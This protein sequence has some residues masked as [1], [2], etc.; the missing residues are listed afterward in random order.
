MDNKDIIKE[1]LEILPEDLKTLILG[2]TWR[3]DIRSIGEEFG[4][5]EEKEILLENEVFMV[6]MG[7]ELKSDFYSNIKETLAIGEDTAKWVSEDV[8]KYVFNQVL[9]ILKQIEYQFNKSV[10]SKTDLPAVNNNIGQSFEK[11]ILN[12]AKAMQPARPADEPVGIM[13]SE[14][15]IMNRKGQ[16]PDNLPAGQ[17]NDV[18]I[19]TPRYTGQD[20]YRE[21]IE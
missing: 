17:K 6:L 11:I 21:T 18:G 10:Q 16:V 19:G 20:P 15:G 7:F 3:T 1:R 9:S 4:F 5:D 13:N 12:Q 2:D 14:S 8:E